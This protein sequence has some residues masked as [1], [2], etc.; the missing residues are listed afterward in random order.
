MDSLSLILGQERA[1]AFLRQALARQRLAP[2]Y[3]FVG[4]EGVG[5]RLAAQGF[6][7]EILQWGLTE[8]Q[9]RQ[10]RRKLW[11]KNHADLLWVEPTYQHQGEFLTAQQAADLGIKRKT[12]PQIRVE[13]IREIARF[14]ARPP[15]EASRSVVVIAEAQTMA[16]GAANA[17]LKT[18]EEPGRATLILLAPAV[19]T[20]LP[21]LVSRCQRVPFS[22]LDQTTLVEVLRLNGYGD[23]CGDR[24]LL[25]IAQGCPGAAILGFQQLQ[26]LPPELKDRLLSP[27]H[28]PYGAMQ[29]AQSIAKALEVETQLWLVDYL[30]YCYWRNTGEAA[31]LDLLEQAKK[32]LRSYVQPRLV[33]ECTLLKLQTLWPALVHQDN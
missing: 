12:L 24:A 17:L 32:Q 23:L 29:L 7:E 2:A 9:Q 22:R 14:L 28:H 25:A 3:L 27:P 26:S 13:Q 19:D 33:W 5:K 31:I 8:T 18:L 1:I 10:T 15:L 11:D 4:P 30:Q 6:G 21:T 20:L 16:E